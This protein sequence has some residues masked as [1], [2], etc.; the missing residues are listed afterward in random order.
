MKLHLHDAKPAQSGEKHGPD[1]PT[2]AADIVVD[3]EYQVEESIA[4]IAKDM[5]GIVLVRCPALGCSWRRTGERFE[6]GP[7]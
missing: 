6:R 2:H 7:L 1:G 3:Y 5:P 4:E